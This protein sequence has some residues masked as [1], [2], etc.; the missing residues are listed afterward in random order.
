MRAEVYDLREYKSKKTQNDRVKI[1]MIVKHFKRELVK[2]ENG[3]EYL[4]MILAF[5]E[6]TETK[7]K[8]VIYM[9]MYGERKVYARPYDMFMSKV[10]KEKYPQVK[11]RYR[12]EE[13]KRE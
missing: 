1:G 2:H 5:A 6:H 7:E 11:Q 8:L 12:F 10:D 9:A 13:Y 3:D 4:Y